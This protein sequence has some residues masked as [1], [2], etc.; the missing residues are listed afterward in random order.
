MRYMVRYSDGDYMEAQPSI[1]ASSDQEA[2]EIASE[3][4]REWLR[5]GD[6]GAAKAGLQRIQGRV[7]IEREGGD[8]REL[9]APVSVPASECRVPPPPESTDA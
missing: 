7:F 5:G 4:C 1:T 9:G 3:G 2:A 8:G 6:W